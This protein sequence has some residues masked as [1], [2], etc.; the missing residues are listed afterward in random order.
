MRNLNHHSRKSCWGCSQ[1]NL[2]DMGTSSRDHRAEESRAPAGLA[3]QRPVREMET[4]RPPTSAGREG[5]M[6]KHRVAHSP[7]CPEDRVPV[8]ASAAQS[9]AT[10]HGSQTQ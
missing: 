10:D 4:A 9:W 6:G 1:T 8:P 7:F 3:Q 5:R 2:R